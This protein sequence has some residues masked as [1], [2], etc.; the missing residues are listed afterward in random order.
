MYSYM[1]MYTYYSSYVD[2]V[3]SLTYRQSTV[4]LYLYLSLISFPSYLATTYR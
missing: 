3:V 1:Y 4:D 2:L